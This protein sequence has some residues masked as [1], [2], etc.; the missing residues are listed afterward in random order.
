MALKGILAELRQGQRGAAG[1]AQGAEGSGVA[2][3]TA[4]IARKQAEG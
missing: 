3:L 1:P 4:R 2:D